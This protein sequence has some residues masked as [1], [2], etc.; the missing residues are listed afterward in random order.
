MQDLIVYSCTGV[1]IPLLA[2][3]ILQGNKHGPAMKLKVRG[4]QH[5]E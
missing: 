4:I 3:L 1:Y 2:S 5:P